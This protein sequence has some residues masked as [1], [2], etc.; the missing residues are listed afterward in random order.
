MHQFSFIIINVQIF[1][2]CCL[3]SFSY[4]WKFLYCHVT[5]PNF[6]ML[7]DLLI[8]FYRCMLFYGNYTYTVPDFT[9]IHINADEEN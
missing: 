6:K 3:I 5:Y 2:L 4:A 7:I 1:S 9:E 8:K